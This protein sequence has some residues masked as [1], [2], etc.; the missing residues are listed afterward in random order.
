MTDG[1]ILLSGLLK[2][3]ML[4]QHC[5]RGTLDRPMDPGLREKMKAQ[6]RELDAIEA[7]ARLLAVQRGWELQEPD[8]GRAMAAVLVMRAGSMGRNADSVIAGRMIQSYTKGM[9]R[10]LRNLHAYTGQ[11]LS[12]RILCRRLLD[13]ET[14]AIRQLQQFL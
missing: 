9:V 11:D 7:D 4:E 12:L 1:K 3:T 8:P 10:G 6:L 2:T 5:I 14:A 13:C